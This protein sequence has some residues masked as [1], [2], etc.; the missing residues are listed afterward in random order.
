MA[1]LFDL[2]KN[3]IAKEMASKFNLKNPMAIPRI[4]K[5]VIN[6]GVGKATQDPSAPIVKRASGP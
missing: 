4:D 5:I 2:Y 1:R 3:D 6:M